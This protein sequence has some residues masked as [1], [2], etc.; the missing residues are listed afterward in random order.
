[1]DAGGE[2]L[3]LDASWMPPRT[4]AETR[5]EEL[6]LAAWH[7]FSRP[8]EVALWLSSA[9][10]VLTRAACGKTEVFSLESDSKDGKSKQYHVAMSVRKRPLK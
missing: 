3:Q 9:C 5:N 10:I 1:M 4:T 2:P 6:L 7:R 8:I